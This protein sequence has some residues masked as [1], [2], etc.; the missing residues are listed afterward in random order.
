MTEQ[1]KLTACNSIINRWEVL[2]FCAFVAV[3]K[4]AYLKWMKKLEITVWFVFTT[5][6]VLLLACH[7]MTL[8]LG[9]CSNATLIRWRQGSVFYFRRLKADFLKVMVVL[10]WAQCLCGEYL[11]SRAVYDMD[12]QSLMKIRPGYGLTILSLSV[13]SGPCLSLAPGNA[14]DRGQFH[15]GF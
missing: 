13:C 11:Q 10:L 14:Y 5:L 2:L 3:F 7:H 6:Q 15:H 1:K 12:Q 8:L 4:V 9:N